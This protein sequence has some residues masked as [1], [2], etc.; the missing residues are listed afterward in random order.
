[1]AQIILGGVFLVAVV[2]IVLSYGRS[3]REGWTKFATAHGLTFHP[4]NFLLGGA[5]IVGVYR[6]HSLIIETFTRNKVTRTRIRLKARNSSPGRRCEI[7]GGLSASPT[8]QEVL[9]LLMPNG[10]LGIT[11]G[12]VEA[13]AGGAYL[14][15][16]QIGVMAE[17]DELR[18]AC[19][20]LSD[21]LDGYPV[22][23]AIGGAA[24]HPLEKIGWRSDL[25]LLSGVA[26]RIMKD[27]AQATRRQL[28]DRAGQLL[29]PRC[30]VHCGA[31]RADL[32]LQPDVTYYG[33]R[34]CHQSRE[35]ID[36][37][38]DVVAVLDAAWQGAQGRRGGLLCVNWL[39]RRVLFDFDQVE[40]VRAK[41]E[42]VERFAVQVGNDTDP[43]RKPRYATM[44]CVVNP[45]CGLSENTLRVLESTFGQV[46]TH[47]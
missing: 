23:V 27:I 39:A 46:E 16:Q 7:A 17:V 10:P 42:D 37:P 8:S 1:M 13:A 26:I 3:E 45:A 15:Y 32:P 47:A 40:I 28:S 18:S 31:H 22:V 2:L 21:M 38:Q 19:N 29:C 12:K 41:D 35:F 4:G 30:L 20:L 25:L 34:A 44:R 33:C 11:S 14:T 24:V 9:D 43:L 36:C 5:R 6:G